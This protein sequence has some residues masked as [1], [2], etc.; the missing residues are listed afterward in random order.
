MAKV[1]VDTLTDNC[2]HNCEDFRIETINMFGD[3]ATYHRIHTC[4]NVN[5][6][7]RIAEVIEN[8]LKGGTE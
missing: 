5:K 1:E 3:G 2:W 4:E 8:E 6:C 7:R